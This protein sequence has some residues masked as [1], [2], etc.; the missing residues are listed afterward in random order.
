MTFSEKRHALRR[1][2]SIA[3]GIRALVNSFGR[4]GV[5]DGLFITVSRTDYEAVEFGLSTRKTFVLDTDN[6]GNIL[7]TGKMLRCNFLFQRSGPSSY[8]Q[9]QP[10]HLML[11]CIPI[12]RGDF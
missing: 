5:P 11:K 9:A 10:K 8:S 12:V 1:F 7:E 2:R 3:N 4:K 6:D